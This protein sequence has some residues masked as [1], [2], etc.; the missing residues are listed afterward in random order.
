MS[1]DSP[2]V[3]LRS[4]WLVLSWVLGLLSLV[5]G[6]ATVLSS[7]GAVG[8]V[9]AGC[10]MLVPGAW[11]WARVPFMRVALHPGG[12]TYH[13]L[14]RNRGFDWSSVRDVTLE[15]VGSRAV[16]T[17]YAP[18]LRLRDGGE[19]PLTMLAGYTTGARAPRSRMA[20]QRQV[21]AG[22]LKAASRGGGATRRPGLPASG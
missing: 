20:R 22:Q 16:A 12:L 7:D 14:F 5:T 8:G 6:L 18:V 11:V 4:P 21:V 2:P 15:V 17:A 1:S 10:L 3:M 13:G 9:L 19:A